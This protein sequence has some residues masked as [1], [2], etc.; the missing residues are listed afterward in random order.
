MN[1]NVVTI[2]GGTGTFAVLSSLRNIP[3]LSLSA[4]VTTADDGGSTG[5]LRDAYG[6]LPAGDA[7]QALVALAEDGDVLRDLFAY[8]FTKSDLAGHSLGNLFITALTDL[9][10][11]DQ[12]GLEEASKILRVSGTVIPATDTSSTIIA[13]LTDGSIVRNEHEIDK[14]IKERSRIAS[15]A[16]ETQTPLAAKAKEAIEKA[17][18]IIVGPG[19]LYTSSIAA[20]LPEGMKEAIAASNA[21]LVYV[22]NLFTKMGQTDEYSLGDHVKEIGAYTGKVPDHILVHQGEFPEEVLSWYAKEGEYP[23]ED[24]LVTDPR[25]IRASLASVNIVPPLPNDPI[26]RSLM[27]HDPVLLAEAL[28]PLL[29]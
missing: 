6:F 4:V 27:R 19:D 18:V 8:R 28:R 20:L 26:R 12:A 21:R 16:L 2:G 1:K 23:V 5:H 7:R 29:A 22:A 10:G 3:G 14:Q 25:V 24:D 15:L 13:T 17:D 9:L 11:S